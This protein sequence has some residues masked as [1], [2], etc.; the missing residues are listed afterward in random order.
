[1]L[2]SFVE[3]TG[4]WRFLEDPE[5][6]EILGRIR[7]SRETAQDLKKIETRLIVEK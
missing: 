2:N 7:M 4:T 1:V 5:W 6:G 3:L